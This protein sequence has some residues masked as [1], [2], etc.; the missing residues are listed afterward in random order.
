MLSTLPAM[1]KPKRG[2]LNVWQSNLYATTEDLL[3]VASLRALL[4]RMPIDH[5]LYAS[6]YPFEERGRGMMNELKE[7]GV[8]GAEEWERIA[9]G[10]AVD[11]FSLRSPA[12]GGRAT[13]GQSWH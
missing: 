8:V 11:L 5:V 3:D 9:R 2:F 7:S 12:Q 6:N 10:N 1:N 13:V 4:E